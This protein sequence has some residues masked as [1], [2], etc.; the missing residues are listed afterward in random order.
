M[1]KHNRLL[2]LIDLSVE[3][4]NTTSQN[5][6]FNINVVK[7]FFNKKDK[8]PVRNELSKLIFQNQETFMTDFKQ[9]YTK[10]NKALQLIRRKY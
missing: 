1:K 10:N 9:Y 4:K 7:K 6:C 8:M 5:K 2:D 3:I